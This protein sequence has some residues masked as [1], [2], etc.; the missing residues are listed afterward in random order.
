VCDLLE[1]ERTS[2][3]TAAGFAEPGRHLTASA[4]SD[5]VKYFFQSSQGK[6]RHDLENCECVMIELD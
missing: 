6:E 2:L 4:H 1:D 5:F 3:E